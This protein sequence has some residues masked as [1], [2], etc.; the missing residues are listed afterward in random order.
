MP[1]DERYQVWCT[2]VSAYSVPPHKGFICINH[3][4]GD[5]LLIAKNQ[6]TLKKL[7]IPKIFVATDASVNA[8]FNLM[9]NTNR[10]CDEKRR[11]TSGIIDAVD[12]VEIFTEPAQSEGVHRSNICDNCELSKAEKESIYQDYVELEAKRCV[13]VANLENCIKKLKM[14]AEISKQHIK[15]LSTKV[16]RK[17]K[18]EESL[19]SLLKDLKE[20]N[21]LS[22]QAYETLEV[23][24]LF[25]GALFYAVF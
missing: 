21:V 14:D 16:Y 11:L 22:T 19:K 25:V 9:E 20:Q 5:D 8:Q 17:E 23:C 4:H 6:T 2:T 1:N 7:A 13:E 24:V 3:F 15:Y 10:K 12:P 18:S